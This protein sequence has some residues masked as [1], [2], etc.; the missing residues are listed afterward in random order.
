MSFGKCF[1]AGPI[2][3]PLPTFPGLQPGH[4]PEG[5]W[6]QVLTWSGVTLQTVVH[7][8]TVTPETALVQWRRLS[9]LAP[10]TTGSFQ[11]QLDFNISP[12]DMNL[13]VEVFVS[14]PNVTLTVTFLGAISLGP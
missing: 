8:V 11:G 4:F 3:K 2:F 5:Q 14:D 9:P 12:T 6:V 10:M 1:S 7:R 13:T